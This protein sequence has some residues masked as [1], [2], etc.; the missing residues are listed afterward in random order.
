MKDEVKKRIRLKVW[1]V[2]FCCMASRAIHTDIA[3][4]QSA[5]GFLLA[6]QRFTALRRHPRKLW[7]DPGSNFVGSKPALKDLYSFLNLIQNSRLEDEAARNGTE[8]SWKLHSADSP[9]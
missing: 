6:Y 2:V 7:T 3:S 1:A 9:H 5:E 8:W 4:D